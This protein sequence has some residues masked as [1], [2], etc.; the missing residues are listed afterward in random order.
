MKNR[1]LSR[2]LAL[3]LAI[4][5]ALCTTNEE[6]TVTVQ[7]EYDTNA[8]LPCPAL[9]YSKHYISLT[10]YKVSPNKEGII[11]NST[12]EGKPQ[13]YKNYENRTDVSL[14]EEGSLVL[15]KVN[16]S[17]AGMYK[18]YLAGKVG[19]RN[20]E[21]FVI[22]NVTES[23]T[24]TTPTMDVTSKFVHH[25][26]ELNFSMV[27]LVLPVDVSPLSVLIGFLSLSLSK[28]LLCFVCV[29]GMASFKEHQRR[30]LW[31]K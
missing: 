25:S 15:Q 10:W 20:N 21:S 4:Y 24:E 19:H 8:F 6:A 13:L 17:Q 28:A 14:T 3:C 12:K 2:I 31:A 11:R 27:G 5:T 22:L 1:T 18:C 9:S 23:V 30:K 26:T 16:F 7:S 29:G